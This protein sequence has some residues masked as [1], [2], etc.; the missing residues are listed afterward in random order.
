MHCMVK[1]VVS[2]ELINIHATPIS[3]KIMIVWVIFIRI[4]RSGESIENV[5]FNHSMI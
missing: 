2:Q 1:V 4:G 5:K 3:L